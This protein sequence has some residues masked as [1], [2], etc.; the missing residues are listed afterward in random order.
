M[1]VQIMNLTGRKKAGGCAGPACEGCGL[2]PGQACLFMAKVESRETLVKMLS[3]GG[4]A[5][6]SRVPGA[7]REGWPVENIFLLKGSAPCRM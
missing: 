5:L 4:R 6:V 1:P 2:I 3:H 7:G